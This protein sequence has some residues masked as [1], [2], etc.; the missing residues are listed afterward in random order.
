MDITGFNL[1]GECTRAIKEFSF[2][3]RL[4]DIDY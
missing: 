2:Y 1:N 4:A 3:E